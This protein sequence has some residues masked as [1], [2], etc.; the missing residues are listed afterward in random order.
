MTTMAAATL[1]SA[2]AAD[3]AQTAALE[4]TL[5]AS[6]SATRALEKWC[7]ARGIADHPVVL[8]RRLKGEAG[9][10]PADLRRRLA[11]SADAP[12]GY[13]HVELLCGD[14]VLSVAHNWYRRELLTAQMNTVLDTS[15]TPFGKVAGPLGF[16][17]ETIDSRRGEEPGCPPG[18]VLSQIALLRLPGGQPLALVTECYT[19]A[20]IA[21]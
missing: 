21:R 5:A 11:V 6:P 18:T 4:R 15:D 20:A 8:A 12:L 2:C 7:A 13:R 14:R 17:R 9:P 3:P 10:E 16:T 19:R 1:L